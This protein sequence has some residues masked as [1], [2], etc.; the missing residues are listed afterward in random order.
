VG[1]LALGYLDFQ[2]ISFQSEESKTEK[3]GP[4]FNRIQLISRGERDVW[5]MQQSHHGITPNVKTWDRLAI[6]VDRTKFPTQARF[7]Q[8]KPGPLEWKPDIEKQE[9]RVSCF[10]CHSNGPRAIRPQW[11]SSDV[12]LSLQ[13]KAR[14]LLWNLRIK[15]YG[16]IVYDPIHDDEDH[17]ARVPFRFHTSLE[18]DRLTG[19]SCTQCHTDSGFFARGFLTR[20]NAPTIGFMISKEHMPPLWLHLSNSDR[21]KIEKFLEGF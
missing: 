13:D 6:V 14:I 20:Q 21:K 7:Y 4:V 10:M 18:N 2:P 8:L 12:R 16:R 3:G 15:S 17:E 9:F 5:M 19:V 1:S 11:D